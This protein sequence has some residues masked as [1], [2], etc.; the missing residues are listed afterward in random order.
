MFDILKA[1]AKEN[2]LHH[3]YIVRGTYNIQVRKAV[4]ELVRNDHFLV[5]YQF[6]RVLKEQASIV[7]GALT[8]ARSERTIIV[9]A[10]GFMDEN[11]QQVFLKALEEP[12]LN[13]H[14]I[15]VAPAQLYFIPTIL[16]RCIEVVSKYEVVL[17]P[18]PL[19][20]MSYSFRK[21][22]LAKVLRADDARSAGLLLLS[23]ELNYAHHNNVFDAIKR[24]TW[25][26]EQLTLPGTPI[27]LILE[28]VIATL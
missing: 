16:S 21:K 2:T 4:R 18:T 25:G 6:D 27:K 10:I 20:D 28:H 1:H 7:R 13:T 23:E 15:I 8:L 12:A 5:E 11:I 3:A 24:L 19:I 9:F 22:A 14:I 17:T 26:I